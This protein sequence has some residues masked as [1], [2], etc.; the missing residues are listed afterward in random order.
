M[1]KLKYYIYAY[2]RTDGTPYYIGKGH[3]NRAWNLHG[4][5][6]VPKNNNRIIIMESNLTEFGAFA[7]ERFYIRW[8]GKKSEKT[9]ILINLAD[10]GEGGCCKKPPRTYKH[11]LNLSL[12]QKGKKISKEHRDK[13]EIYYKKIRGS[14]RSEISILK[15]KETI[16][17]KIKDGT[18][19][20]GKGRSI[21]VVINGKCYKNKKTAA[22]E[23]GIC[24]ITLQK[25]L[26]N[27][28]IIIDGKVMPIK[29]YN[30][31]KMPVI[32]NG[33]VYDSK[34][35]AMRSLHIGFKKLNNIIDGI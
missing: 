26:K 8:Y 20:V 1:D 29:D 13:L 4:R 30:G 22:I 27:E 10:G 9:G 19:T 35:S 6:P 33:V 28:R 2:I 7:L 11:R 18:F 21:E 16:K 3:G 5:I 23:L 17:Q 15:Q 25:L 12:S 24:Y 31:R 34:I 32:I 14:K